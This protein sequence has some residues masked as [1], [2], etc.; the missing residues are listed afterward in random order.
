MDKKR[1]KSNQSKIRTIITNAVCGEATE[2]FQTAVYIT[3]D[4]KKPSKILGCTIKNTEIIESSFDEISPKKMDITVNGRFEVHVWYEA[5]GDTKVAKNIVK[6]S[7]NIQLDKIEDNKYYNKHVLAWINKSPNIV[8]TMVISKDG[9]PSISVEVEY[10]IG[11]EVIG[12]A[13]LNI[14]SCNNESRYIQKDEDKMFDSVLAEREDIF[15]DDD[16]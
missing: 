6:F 1:I 5:S 3:T 16:D 12:E 10:E 8:G 11:V 7:E 14:V 4:D 13:R 2:T 15:E 9:K